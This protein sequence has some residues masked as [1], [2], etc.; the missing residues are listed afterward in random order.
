MEKEK[1]LKEND[2]QT[3]T[4]Q[5]DLK[6][7]KKVAKDLTLQKDQREADREAVETSSEPGTTYNKTNMKGNTDEANADQGNT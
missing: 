7:T 6:E 4:S 2:L 1:I 3:A 5:E